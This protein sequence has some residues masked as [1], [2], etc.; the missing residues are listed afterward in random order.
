MR[1]KDS[2][3]QAAKQLKKEFPI[4][5]DSAGCRALRPHLG[6]SFMPP[7]ICRSP[8]D[9]NQRGSTRAAENH[10]LLSSGTRPS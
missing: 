5:G 4:Q 8:E 7:G 6:S 2:K 10:L 1:G 3:R 9:K